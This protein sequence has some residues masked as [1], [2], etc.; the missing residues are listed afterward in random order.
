MNEQ[1][2]CCVF[3]LAILTLFFIS[4][5]IV[6]DL[7]WS[8]HKKKLKAHFCQNSTFMTAFQMFLFQLMQFF[9]FFII[10]AFLFLE[11]NNNVS[12]SCN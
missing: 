1:G 9:I 5:R 7:I 2:R 12:A 4:I 3:F 11:N 6:T 10:Y 8:I